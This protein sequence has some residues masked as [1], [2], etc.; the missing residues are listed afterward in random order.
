MVDGFMGALPESGVREFLQRH[1]GAVE[2]EEEEAL[3]ADDAATAETPEQTIARLQQG[4]AQAPDKAE[5]SSISR[6]PTCVPALPTLRGPSS[7]RCRPISP[8]TRKPDG[9]EPSSS[10]PMR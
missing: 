4:N 8:K 5:L 2:T 10:S 9:C 7:K 6:S 3:P 1:L